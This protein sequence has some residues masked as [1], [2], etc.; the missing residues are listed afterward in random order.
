MGTDKGLMMVRSKPM[1]L[2]VMS[3]ISTVTDEVVITVGE[4]ARHRYEE[5]VGSA[6]I[7]EDRAKGRGPLE[8]LYNGFRRAKGE[9]VVV[10]PCDTPLLKA[11]LLAHLVS[12]ATGKEGSVPVLGGYLEPL[13]AVYERTACIDRFGH[14][15]DSGVGKVGNALAGMDLVFVHEEELRCVDADLRSF[16]N[17]NSPEDRKTVES[18]LD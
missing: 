12:R 6:I 18:M 9:Y 16:M 2:H 1:L 17:V 15:L 4:G 13:I 3:A 5:L 7:V 11:A 8:G 10:A 14:E